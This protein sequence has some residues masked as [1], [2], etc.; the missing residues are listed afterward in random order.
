MI[1][2]Q[3]LQFDF[4]ILRDKSWKLEIPKMMDGDGIGLDEGM[5]HREAGLWRL[6]MVFPLE[7]QTVG[8]HGIQGKLSSNNS[9]CL[10]VLHDL[11]NGV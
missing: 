6:R 9:R 10:P 11:K 5:G 1:D 8:N 7:L 4:G 3:V 2:W